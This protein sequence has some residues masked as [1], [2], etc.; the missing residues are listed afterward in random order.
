MGFYIDGQTLKPNFDKIEAIMK[1]PLPNTKKKLKSFLGVI[2][3]CRMFIPN[4]SY[5]SGPLSDLLKKDVKEPLSWSETLRDKFEALKLALTK[6]SILKLPD[7][8]LPFVLRTDASN[9]G[10]GAVLL[11]YVDGCPLPCAYASRK[12][13]D[14]EKR[15]ST[16]E[17]ECLAIIFGVKRFE[18]YLVGKEFVL[19]VDHKPLIYMNSAKSTNSRLVPWSLSLQAFKFRIVYISGKDNIGADLLCRNADL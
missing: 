7:I 9:C 16:V 8:N 10:L 14:W 12:L 3:F 17:R 15:Y 18:Y 1:I 2:S 6:D 5:L 11:Q 13:L 4:A 19:E